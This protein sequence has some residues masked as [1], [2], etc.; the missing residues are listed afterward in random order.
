M[1]QIETKMPFRFFIVNFL[2]GF[3]FDEMRGIFVTFKYNKLETKKD[4]LFLPE[5]F[6]VSTFLL[7]IYIFFLFNQHMSNVRYREKKAI[8][9][10]GMKMGFLF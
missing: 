3:F 9:R 5:I 10:K 4:A 1:S 6:N 8:I 7:F 2:Q